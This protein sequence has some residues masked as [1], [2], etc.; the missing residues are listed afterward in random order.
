M[1]FPAEIIRSAVK[2]ANTLTKGVQSTVRLE[3]FKSQAGDGAK[4]YASAVTVRAV[5]DR[6]R[7]QRFIGGRVVT[8]IA[9]LTILDTVPSQGT[10]GRQEPIDPRDK[11]TLPDGVTGP[12]VSVG[13]V[14]D[15]GTGKGFI[16]SVTLGEA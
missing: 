6:K 8:V 14:D 15:P 13:A 12:I 7:Y 4:I 9:K 1:A 11:I 10:V 5:V 2:T 3:Q 16:Q